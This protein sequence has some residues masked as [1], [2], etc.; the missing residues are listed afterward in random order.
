MVGGLP[1]KRNSDSVGGELRWSPG[2]PAWA[3]GI[4]IVNTNPSGLTPA[5][6]YHYNIS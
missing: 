4:T 2:A 5:P 3:E 6:E 1:K